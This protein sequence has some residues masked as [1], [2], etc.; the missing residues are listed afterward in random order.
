M[1]NGWEGF[2]TQKGEEYMLIIIVLIVVLLVVATVFTLLLQDNYKKEKLL[3]E[4]GLRDEEIVK[5]A[6]KEAKTSSKAI[7]ITTRIV[8]WIFVGA[9]LGLVG[10][11]LI[12]QFTYNNA[13]AQGQFTLVAV[14]SGSMSEINKNNTV[15]QTSG[16]TDQ[17]Q[18]NDLIVIRSLPSEEKDKDGNLNI[19]LFD[20]IAYHHTKSNSLWIHRVVNIRDISGT[21][22]Y[23]LRGDANPSQDSPD[24]EFSDMRGQYKG[25]RTPGIGGIV[26]FVQSPMG[27]ITAAVCVYIAV[28][29]DVMGNRTRKLERDRLIELDRRKHQFQLSGTDKNGISFENLPESEHEK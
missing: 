21:I 29:V 9:I 6:Q 24:I 23:T 8:S 13:P 3:I 27:I 4:K 2:H 5:E 19:K 16:K 14:A 25:E 15:V 18:Q 12:Q 20:V 26:L 10:F 22:K 1:Y 11:S 28:I 17:F 7:R